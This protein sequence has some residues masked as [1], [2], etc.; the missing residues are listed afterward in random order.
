MYRP[1][2]TPRLAV[3][4]DRITREHVSARKQRYQTDREIGGRRAAR[5]SMR[6]VREHRDSRRR[7]RSTHAFRLT[8]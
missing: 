8:E 5:H 3:S 6:L 2:Q 4:S 1:S 7:R